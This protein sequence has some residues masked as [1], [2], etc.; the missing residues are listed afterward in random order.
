MADKSG[1]RVLPIGTRHSFADG[2]RK[3]FGGKPRQVLDSK[4]KKILKLVWDGPILS[5]TLTQAARKPLPSLPFHPT[6]SENGRVLQS[7]LNKSERKQQQRATVRR[8]RATRF[9]LPKDGLY[10][11]SRSVSKLTV[12]RYTAAAAAFEKWCKQRGLKATAG[13]LLDLALA[14]YADRLF[15][16]GRGIQDARYGPGV[17]DT[18]GVSPSARRNTRSCMS[19]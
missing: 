8:V 1:K 15:F 6:T 14:R 2:G 3:S 18:L 13:R 7:I 11:K 10:L 12:E 5:S 19:R 9:E 4:P 17:F 16:D